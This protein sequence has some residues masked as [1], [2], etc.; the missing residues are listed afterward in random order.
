M[1]PP[2]QRYDKPAL[3]ENE[4]IERYIERG[5]IITDRNRAARYLR[6]IGYYRLSPYTIPFQADRTTH[7]FKSGTT[8]DDILYIYVFDRQLRLM[9]MDA[10]ERIEV[11]VR[12]AVSNTMSIH[13]E[14][15]AFWYQN[16]S[17]YRSRKGY[18]TTIERI[19]ALTERERQRTPSDRGEQADHLHYPDALSHYLATYSSP[20]TPPSWL[21]IELLTAGELHHL[22]AN[23]TLRYRKKIARELNLPDQ[24]LQSWLKT[25]VRVRNICAHHG[26]LWNRF[27]GVYP[28]IPK[29]RT[30]RW[31]NERS[32]FDTS[33]PRALERKRLY[34][35]LVSLQSILFTISPHSTWALRLHS[36]LGK[37]QRIPL[38]APGM[39]ANWDTD[40]FW[41]EAFEAGS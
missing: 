1:N 29:S 41:Q 37:Y 22:Y 26:R 16:A 34:P 30:V 39:K 27:L 18:S 5:L 21:V 38:N 40:E 6:H 14:G 11:A 28:V 2:G 13:G 9:T 32:V 25:Y 17:N 8:F 10:L 20:E 23:L 19:E 33:N 3:D 7:S 31:L 35:V 24:V 4:L 15:G 36:L 12:A